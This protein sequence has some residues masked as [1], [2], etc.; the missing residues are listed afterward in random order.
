MGGKGLLLLIITVFL[1]MREARSKRT[2]DRRMKS[3]RDEAGEEVTAVSSP[4]AEGETIQEV[5]NILLLL[6]QRRN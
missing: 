3:L 6:Q 1:P 5:A 4:S 2:Q